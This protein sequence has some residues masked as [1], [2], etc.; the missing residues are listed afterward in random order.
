MPVLKQARHR[1]YHINIYI[2][3]TIIISECKAIEAPDNGHILGNMVNVGSTIALRCND[4]YAYMGPGC[5]IGSATSQCQTNDTH[6]FWSIDSIKCLPGTC[7]TLYIVSI[8][9][10]KLSQSQLPSKA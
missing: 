7:L 4:G 10:L 1:T 3:K 2:Y 6:A 8:S 9:V 5:D